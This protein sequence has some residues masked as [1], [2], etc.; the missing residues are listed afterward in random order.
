MSKTKD[1]SQDVKTMDTRRPSQV[2][3]AM[4]IDTDKEK[5]A[6]NVP[7]ERVAECMRDF[8]KAEAERKQAAEAA[9]A[10]KGLNDAARQIAE[11]KAALE[12]EKAKNRAL[13]DEA[14]PKSKRVSFAIRPSRFYALQAVAIKT[15]DAQA[16]IV[17]RA[18]EQEYKI[19]F[20]G[21]PLPSAEDIQQMKAAAPKGGE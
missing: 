12:A 3:A 8:D 15:G 19:V 9:A 7:P 20:K 10:P 11:L 16:A 18:L 4:G 13:Q 21:A 14:E 5:A 2:A 1:F 6:P 17:E